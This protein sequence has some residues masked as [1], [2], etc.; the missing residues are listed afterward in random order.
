MSVPDPLH[1][2]YSFQFTLSVVME[3]VDLFLGLFLLF[4]CFVKFQWF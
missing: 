2:Y 1:I 3:Q 4:V